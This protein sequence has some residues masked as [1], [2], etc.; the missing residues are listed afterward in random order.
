MADL[1]LMAA[2]LRGWLACWLQFESCFVALLVLDVVLRAFVL[3]SREK[4][5]WRYWTQDSGRAT[6]EVTSP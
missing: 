5:C 2:R 3:G 6:I 4:S 1:R